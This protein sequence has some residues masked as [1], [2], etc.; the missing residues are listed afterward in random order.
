M[1][2]EQSIVVEPLDAALDELC[3]KFGVWGTSLALLGVAFRRRRQ[4]NSLRHMSNRMRRDIGVAEV[5][6]L[7]LPPR[8]SVWDIRL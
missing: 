6:D 7:L 1:H 2:Q 8:F 4:N 5:D 3:Q